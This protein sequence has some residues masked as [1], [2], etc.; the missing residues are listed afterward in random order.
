[1]YSGDISVLVKVFQETLNSVESH[2][3]MKSKDQI[4]TLSRETDVI[5]SSVN[6]SNETTP[7]STTVSK[8][9]K[10]SK[11]E[12]KSKNKDKKEAKK[13][14]SGYKLLN[15]SSSFEN[16]E[17]VNTSTSISHNSQK[18]SSYGKQSDEI[19]VNAPSSNVKNSKLKSHKGALEEMDKSSMV[20]SQ[21]SV[22]VKASE[23][24]CKNYV[25]HMNRLEDNLLDTKNSSTTQFGTNLLEDICSGVWNVDHQKGFDKV[26]SCMNIEGT[27]AI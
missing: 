12:R 16:K 10:R 23:A 26:E 18:N 3:C 5:V 25:G 11:K 15:S 1:M 27:I 19:K 14:H 9:E 13:D 4:Q 8:D 7:V 24:Q 6:S 21:S 22:T 17:H 2:G 20:K